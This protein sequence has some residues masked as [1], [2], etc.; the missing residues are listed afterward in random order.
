MARPARNCLAGRSETY[1]QVIEPS[2]CTTWPP[3][4]LSSLLKW[5]IALV[6]SVFDDGHLVSWRYATFLTL[7]FL[8]LFLGLGPLTFT[9]FFGVIATSK[10]VSA[11]WV[12]R[13]PWRAA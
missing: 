9:M 5:T 2:F 7:R 4:V 1:L 11:I 6:G 10:C 8:C 12:P 3:G 13:L